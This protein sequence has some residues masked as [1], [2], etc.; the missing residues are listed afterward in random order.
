MT[1][2]HR[3]SRTDPETGLTQI[4]SFEKEDRPFAPL[5]GGK[6]R[7]EESFAIPNP[8]DASIIDG[9]VYYDFSANGLYAVYCHTMPLRGLVSSG[10]FTRPQILGLEVAN[11]GHDGPH[12]LQF[13]SIEK[14][15][16]GANGST[17]YALDYLHLPASIVEEG[18]HDHMNKLIEK[19]EHLLESNPDLDAS[20]IDQI[21]EFISEIGMI[22]IDD[23]ILEIYTPPRHLMGMEHGHYVRPA[24]GPFCKFDN[25][26]TAVFSNT[27]PKELMRR[28]ELD[29][30]QNLPNIGLIT[31][32]DALFEMSVYALLDK[33]EQPNKYTPSP[34]LRHR[35]PPL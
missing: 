2:I 28:L 19:M 18:F 29:I 31:H 16:T 3:G 24:Q 11:D 21:S 22:D 17:N 4:F 13:D 6:I 10:C 7:V 15:E 27:P 32:F 5:P 12:F 14:Y 30:K 1:D 23:V 33:F 20:V 26:L 9:L 35:S 8:E 25:P 34:F